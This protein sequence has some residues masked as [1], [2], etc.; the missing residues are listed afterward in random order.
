MTW[1]AG[2]KRH[3][4]ICLEKGLLDRLIREEKT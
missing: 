3:G 1:A 2:V 4:G